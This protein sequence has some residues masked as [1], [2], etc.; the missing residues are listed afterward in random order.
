MP[1]NTQDRVQSDK[2]KDLPVLAYSRL[3][4]AAGPAVPLS[5]VERFQFYEAAKSCFCV[6]QTTDATPYANVIISKGVLSFSSLEPA[7]VQT[8]PV[9]VAPAADT[10]A[11]P[12]KAPRPGESNGSIRSP[13]RSILAAKK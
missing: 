3:Q 2:D 9:A 13:R 12:R 6:I 4:E 10:D 8:K 5:Y 1:L 11:P 7:R